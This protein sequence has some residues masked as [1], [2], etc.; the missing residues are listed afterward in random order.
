MPDHLGMAL[1]APPVVELVP[2]PDIERESSG[3]FKKARKKFGQLAEKK[4]DEAKDSQRGMD[5][6]RKMM[7]AQKLMDQMKRLEFMP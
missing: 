5:G 7:D 2:P 1:G 4:I 3:E 6:D